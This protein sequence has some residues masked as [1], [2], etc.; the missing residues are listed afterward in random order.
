MNQ[1]VRTRY[2]P[3][4]TGMQ[5]IGGVRTALF[6]YLFTKHH[7]GDFILRIEDTDQSRFVEGAEQYIIDTLEWLD[8]ECA[9]GVHVGGDAGPYRQSER[10]PLYKKYAQQLLDSG[11]AYMAFDTAEELAAIR[12]K[13]EADKTNF[14]YGAET[15]LMMKNSLTLSEEEVKSRLE[16]GDPYVIRIKVPQDRKIKVHDVIRGEIEFHSDEVDD[17]VLMKADGMPTYHLAVVVDDYSMKISH[18]FRGVEWLPSFPIHGLLYEFLGLQDSMPKF[19]HTPLIMKPNGKGKLSKRDGDLGGFPVF[20]LAWEG[21]NGFREMGFFPD[22][23]KNILA[24]LGWNPGTEQEIFTEDELA[25]AFDLSRISKAGAKF[26]FEKAKWFNQQYLRAKTNEELAEHVLK[27]APEEVSYDE[28]QIPYLCGLLKERMT[29]PQDF[30]SAGAYFFNKP[31]EFDAKTV[32]K[33]WNDDSIAYFTEIKQQLSD[34]STFDVDNV[35]KTVKDYIAAKELKFGDIL[36]P[37]RLMLSGVKGGPSVFEIAAF[38]GK[39]ETLAR[40]ELAEA[41]FAE[42]NAV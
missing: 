17:K 16:A 20:P 21:Q 10:K 28:S 4:P 12:K 23:F 18:V 2:A 34:L 22:A 3:S 37:F 38:L 19:V 27:Y 30:W 8:M 41:K 24:F 39:E 7:N 5:H 31:S 26:D 40:M 25:A 32:K 14:K 6:C 1:K 36:L 35:E 42:M 9:E 33:K 29:Y 15:R 13:Y 11:H